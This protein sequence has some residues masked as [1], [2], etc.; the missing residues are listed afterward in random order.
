MENF[1]KGKNVLTHFNQHGK[2]ESK[3]RNHIV[4]CVVDF[5]LQYGPGKMGKSEFERAANQI[6]Q[7]F[8]NEIKVTII[9]TLFVIEPKVT[10]FRH[11]FFN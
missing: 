7:H 11:L 6:I 8:P 10:I 1:I 9:Y 4:E 2:I 3:H 5:Y